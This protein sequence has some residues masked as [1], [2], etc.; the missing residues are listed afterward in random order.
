VFLGLQG[1]V[2]SRLTSRP[3]GVALLPAKE[4]GQFVHSDGARLISVVFK[5]SDSKLAARKPKFP[6]RVT[7]QQSSCGCAISPRGDRR[8]TH[9]DIYEPFIRFKEQR[10]YQSNR[11]YRS[12]Y[13]MA[14]KVVNLRVLEK[15]LYLRTG[16]CKLQM[17]LGQFKKPRNVPETLIPPLRPGG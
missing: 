1:I 11:R 2:S 4:Y 7:S 12:L 16:Y 10:D 15:F 14:G 13:P 9:N 5:S 8:R 3:S 17:A 6:A